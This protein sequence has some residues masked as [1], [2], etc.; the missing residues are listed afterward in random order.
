MNTCRNAR[1][2]FG[3][4]HA[5][6]PVLRSEHG[7]VQSTER[8]RQ[9]QFPG[10]ARSVGLLDNNP[11]APIC[12]RRPADIDADDY[13]INRL[14]DETRLHGL[15]HAADRTSSSTSAKHESSNER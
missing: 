1:R 13:R 7:F 4:E 12:D 14:Y 9:C 5:I 2:I 10:S 15:Q 11:K 8:A 6:V 3:F